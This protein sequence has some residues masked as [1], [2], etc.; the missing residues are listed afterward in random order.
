MGRAS[1]TA[2]AAAPHLQGQRRARYL[3]DL[4]QMVA[5][6]SS[7]F[8][9]VEEPGGGRRTEPSA[10]PSHGMNHRR[11]AGACSMCT[12]ARTAFKFALLARVFAVSAS[13]LKLFA[14]KSTI[15]AF[16]SRTLAL[17]S[18]LFHAREKRQGV[19]RDPPGP[20]RTDP[21]PPDACGSSDGKGEDAGPC[22]S[23]CGRPTQAGSLYVARRAAEGLA[24]AAVAAAA[25]AAA[26]VASSVSGVSRKPASAT[27]TVTVTAATVAAPPVVPSPIHHAPKRVAPQETPAQAECSCAAR[28]HAPLVVVVSTTI[29]TTISAGAA[30]HAALAVAAHGLG[31][32]HAVGPV[33]GLP[34]LHLGHL[35]HL[36]PLLL[37]A[38]D[39]KND[40]DDERDDDERDD[41]GN[42][43][44]GIVVG[45]SASAAAA[46]AAAASAPVAAFFGVAG[47][48]LLR[49]PVKKCG[50]A[51]EGV[52]HCAAERMQHVD[53]LGRG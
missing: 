17:K 16:K 1:E 31:D 24:A 33:H 2:R 23:A 37:P 53:V 39:D 29:S 3:P 11:D 5:K 27:A 8:P 13:G 22:G 42:V 6:Y 25:V 47:V 40:A 50:T 38:T 44:G 30:H 43:S 46:S 35:D 21:H 7:Q 45:V 32:G 51:V 20:R 52:R 49:A 10:E 48:A 19:S 14:F 36:H 12:P 4:T 26:A 34:T 9:A 28:A 41:I 15:T 18:T